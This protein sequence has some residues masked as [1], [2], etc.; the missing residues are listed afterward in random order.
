MT[1]RS[2][3]LGIVS[4]GIGV[5]PARA[6]ENVVYGRVTYED[7]SSHLLTVSV[8]KFSCA[9]LGQAED[10]LPD[11]DYKRGLRGL[12]RLKQKR[13]GITLTA[14]AYPELADPRPYLDQVA[15]QMRTRGERSSLWQQ[16]RRPATFRSNFRGSKVGRDA[17]AWCS[18][19]SSRML[20]SA[21]SFGTA[22]GRPENTG[23]RATGWSG[24]PGGTSSRASE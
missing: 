12:I 16:T 19:A 8:P 20:P 23:T 14:F 13:D 1:R 17:A 3:L 5:T 24:T 10:A 2:F 15:E 18:G 4:V 9:R 21:S 11:E 7:F 22:I 6:G